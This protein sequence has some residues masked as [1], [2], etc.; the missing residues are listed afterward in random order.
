MLWG[1]C[2]GVLF[3]CFPNFFPFRFF[4][5]LSYI[6]MSEKHNGGRVDE[7]C[8]SRCC[9]RSRYTIYSSHVAVCWRSSC[10][11]LAVDVCTL[12]V[13][14]A[15]WRTRTLEVVLVNA[16]DHCT[17]E[18]TLGVWYHGRRSCAICWH[19]ALAAALLY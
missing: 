19:Y 7:S 9:T 13:V 15:G 2:A 4:S 10:S 6:S 18:V 14:I 17:L 12:A 1:Y 5:I 3:L 16:G 11:T 8:R